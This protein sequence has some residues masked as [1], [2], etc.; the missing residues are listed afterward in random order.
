M[1]EAPGVPPSAARHREEV[2]GPRGRRGGKGE[3]TAGGT[4]WR[5]RRAGRGPTRGGQ[6]GGQVCGPRVLKRTPRGKNRPKGGCCSWEVQGTVTCT[7]WKQR[8][9]LL[10]EGAAVGAAGG[11]C[12][13]PGPTGAVSLAGGTGPH[14]RV[15]AVPVGRRESPRRLRAALPPQCPGRARR[16]CNQGWWTEGVSRASSHKDTGLFRMRRSEKIRAPPRAVLWESSSGPSPQ[17]PAEVTSGRGHQHPG[18]TQHPLA[19]APCP[20]P[21]VPTARPAPPQRCT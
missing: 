18:P 2:L 1:R 16:A 13:H 7:P 12:L 8:V 5:R 17:P 21:G 19:R 10:P 6:Q 15:Q 3:R 11:L 9:T 4:G 20:A 14:A